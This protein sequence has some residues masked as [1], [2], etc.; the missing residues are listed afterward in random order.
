MEAKIWLAT[1]SI[2][3][4]SVCKTWGLIHSFSSGYLIN[5]EFL[6]R[7]AGTNALLDWTAY[8]LF[9]ILISKLSPP[10]RWTADGL[11]GLGLALGM[12][13]W[14]I[15]N[16]PWFIRRNQRLIRGIF[17][18][19]R[20]NGIVMYPEGSCFG[21]NLLVDEIKLSSLTVV[22]SLGEAGALSGRACP[23][24]NGDIVW[25]LTEEIS[26]HQYL[27]QIVLADH[28]Q[29]GSR[30]AASYVIS[31]DSRDSTD[32]SNAL[33]EHL[34]ATHAVENVGWTPLRWR[35]WF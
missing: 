10:H 19:Y 32:H 26:P 27:L 30:S 5:Y 3:W 35:S 25:V 29:V 11:V 20:Q 24:G 6:W 34:P 16:D 13:G 22:P 4:P 2:Q 9:G 15:G 18:T 28:F 21:L 12:I 7:A 14:S 17:S 8:E 1:D 31:C 33:C 23:S